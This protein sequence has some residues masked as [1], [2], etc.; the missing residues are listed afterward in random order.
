[1][2]MTG[3]TRQVAA[4]VLVAVALVAGAGTLQGATA[5][6]SAV[7][8]AVA[9]LQR[10]EAGPSYLAAERAVIA[11]Q[12]VPALAKQAL[13]AQVAEFLASPAFAA[14]AHELS[15]AVGDRG[16]PEFTYHLNQGN[17]RMVAAV[18][19]FTVLV[20]PGVLGCPIGQ[21]TCVSLWVLVGA[22]LAAGAVV[23][24]AQEYVQAVLSLP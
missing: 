7:D 11:G 10:I 23:S 22:S 12:P 5:A 21:P 14:A 17:Q 24:G 4:A 9:A 15:P 19:V 6:P 13:E 3:R 2:T 20:V 8:T 1:M 18:N 16:V